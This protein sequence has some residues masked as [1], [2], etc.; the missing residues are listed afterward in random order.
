M[1]ANN[2]NL[3]IQ[4]KIEGEDW[5]ISLTASEQGLLAMLRMMYGKFE[6]M[7]KALEKVPPGSRQV[8]ML[9]DFLVLNR[10]LVFNQFQEHN[11]KFVKINKLK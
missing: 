6:V 10:C 7:L 2:W 9:E 4:T 1:A 8:G 3:H 5:S 11:G